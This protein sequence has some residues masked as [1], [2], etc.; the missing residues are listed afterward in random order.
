MNRAASSGWGSRSASGLAS[1]K[2]Y[3]AAADV[4]AVCLQ[5]PPDAACAHHRRDPAELAGMGFIGSE[6]VGGL[7]QPAVAPQGFGHDRPEREQGQ[8][9]RI[10][11]R[12]EGACCLQHV[13]RV[14]E[15]D[16]Q[17]PVSGRCGSA[18]EL[19]CRGDGSRP[20]QQRR[21][22]ARPPSRRALKPC[23]RRRR[24]P[25]RSPGSGPGPCPAEPCEPVPRRPWRH[26]RRP[27]GSRRLP[28]ATGL[29]ISGCRRSHPGGR[30]SSPGPAS[31]RSARRDH[32]PTKPRARHSSTAVA[33]RGVAIGG[34]EQVPR[35]GRSPGHRQGDAAD[36]Q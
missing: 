20:G 4:M 10:G 13:L 28:A 23:R 22:L 2:A 25:S 24:R 6:P 5:Q 21:G 8:L 27:G 7:V 11:G 18:L 34:V 30:R 19:R 12:I 29:R 15:G 35:V 9:G 1:S 26:R 33:G 36:Q 32:A 14:V 3:S 31:L 17:R 16:G